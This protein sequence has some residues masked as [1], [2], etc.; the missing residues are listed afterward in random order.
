MLSNIGMAYTCSVQFSSGSVLQ[1]AYHDA[2]TL[3]GPKDSVATIEA[4]L[5]TKMESF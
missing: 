3:L 5:S 4:F 1:S 2:G